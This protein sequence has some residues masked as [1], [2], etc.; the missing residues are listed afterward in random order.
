MHSSPKTPKPPQAPGAAKRG[1]SGPSE[2]DPGRSGKGRFSSRR[3]REAV[4]RLL[5]GEDL[6]TLSREL[7]VTA[8]TLS[9]WRETFLFAGEAALKSREPD[10]KDEEVM[11]LKAKIGE[12]TMANELL[13]EKI[14][15]LEGQRPLAPWRPRR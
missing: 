15:A 10:A 6:D 4:V 3:K 5:R 2:A 8:H 9:G 14:D 13:H 11:R 12:I 1:P 7:G